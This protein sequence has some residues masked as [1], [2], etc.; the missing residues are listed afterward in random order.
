MKEFYT[1]KEFA[2]LMA[3]SLRQVHKLIHNGMIRAVNVSIGP[4]PTYR[5]LCKEYL[6][7]IAEQYTKQNIQ[8]DNDGMGETY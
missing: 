6:R 8:G 5:I 3:I 2:K 4:R 7:F 1:T